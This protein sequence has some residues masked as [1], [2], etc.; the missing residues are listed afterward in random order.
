MSNQVVV[1]VV[2]NI[3]MLD[4]VQNQQTCF[5]SGRSS[6]VSSLPDQDIQAGHFKIGC[7]FCSLNASIYLLHIPQMCYMLHARFFLIHAT[8]YMLRVI[9]YV[10]QLL[11]TCYILH[12]ICY[13]LNAT[14]MLNQQTRFFSGRSSVVSFLPD[15]DIKAGHFKIGCS[16]CSRP[17]MLAVLGV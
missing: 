14:S 13:M 17:E 15:Q 2:T 6:V 1:P 7:S 10:L 12:A 3:C 16:F 11:A 8:S 4:P 9:C 5:F